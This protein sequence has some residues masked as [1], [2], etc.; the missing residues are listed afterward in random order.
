MSANKRAI[1][2]YDLGFTA[3]CFACF[4]G[5]FTLGTQTPKTLIAAE[6]FAFSILALIASNILFSIFNLNNDPSSHPRV[7]AAYSSVGFVTFAGMVSGLIGISF[8]FSSVSESSGL[9]F[10]SSCLV[11]ISLIIVGVKVYER[12]GP[13]LAG[14]EAPA[15]SRDEDQQ[16]G[17]KE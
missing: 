2:N 9:W 10:A 4:L 8:M 15:A 17:Q 12:K 11:S 14:D 16:Q 6:F 1:K 7:R 3:V 13:N 5:I